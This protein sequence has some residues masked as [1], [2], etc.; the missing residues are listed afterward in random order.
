M[1]T[2][3]ARRTLPLTGCAPG[4]C[5]AAGSF[6]PLLNGV[7]PTAWHLGRRHDRAVQ[8]SILVCL[9][10]A[11]LSHGSIFSIGRFL[12][13][14]GHRETRCLGIPARPSKARPSG[15]CRGTL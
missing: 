5:P 12:C 14:S 8:D 10:L 7:Y 6:L 11:L 3:T 15:L 9:L 4:F 1:H 2:Q 13:T